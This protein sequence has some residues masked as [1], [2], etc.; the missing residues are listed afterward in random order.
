MAPVGLFHLEDPDIRMIFRDVC[1]LDKLESPEL[2]GYGESA[3][4]DAVQPEIGF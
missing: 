4:S 1:P 3:L 2:P